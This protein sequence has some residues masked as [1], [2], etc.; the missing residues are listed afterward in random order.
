MWRQNS[1]KD[2]LQTFFKTFYFN[3]TF[4]LK[5]IEMVTM[6]NIK[7]FIFVFTIIVLQVLHF[8]MSIP[9]NN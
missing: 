8:E 5:K 1:N 9:K 7:N 4:Y 6:K 3:L 2:V